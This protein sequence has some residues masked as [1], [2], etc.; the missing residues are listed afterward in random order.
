MRKL[1]FIV[2]AYGWGT[3]EITCKASDDMEVD[4]QI[5]SLSSPYMPQSSPPQNN[6]I[7][8]DT[9][10]QGFNSIRSIY[11]MITEGHLNAD[12]H[13]LFDAY[14]AF[15]Q[16][17]LSEQVW[18]TY[19]KHLESDFWPAQKIEDTWK[20]KECV[21]AHIFF[22]SKALEWYD[23]PYQNHF[24][25]RFDV[26]WGFAISAKFNHSLGKYLLADVLYKMRWAEDPSPLTDLFEDNSKEAINELKQC[27]DHPDACYLL[28]RGHSGNFPRLVSCHDEEALLAYNL[29]NRHPQN[30]RNKYRAL[31]NGDAKPTVDTY[32]DLAGQGYVSAYLEAAHLSESI[33]QKEKILKEAS[34]QNY[35]PAFLKLGYL[36]CNQKGEDEQALSFFRQAAEEHGLTAGY[37]AAGRLKNSLAGSS[38]GKT[39]QLIKEAVDFFKKAGEA[40]DPKGWECLIDLWKEKYDI[41][42]AQG[43]IDKKQAY[44]SKL[45][46]AIQEGIKIGSAYAYRHAQIYFDEEVFLKYVKTYG[47]EFQTFK[48]TLFLGR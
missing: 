20:W 35:G 16:L 15:T 42:K 32:L 22:P 6:T 24:L 34:E 23:C 18:E 25:M 36:F 38:Q 40:K 13:K 19:A 46:D 47:N 31:K 45:E 39:D 21:G 44:F 10:E 5:Y 37:I 27:L 2:L 7:S 14:T 30:I 4:Y 26:I 1:I 41:A 28:G 3:G 12:C 11:E 43:N 8:P 48:A 17:S 9:H 29:F 33:Q